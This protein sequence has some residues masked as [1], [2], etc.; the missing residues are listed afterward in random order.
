M[1]GTSKNGSAKFMPITPAR[2]TAGRNT[3]D[4][5][6]RIHDLFASCA[7]RPMWMSNVPS[8]GRAGSDRVEG[9]LQ[10]IGQAG[11]RLAEL[12]VQGHLRPARAAKAT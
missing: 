3:A 7:A 9:A 4:R 1:I 6:V 10:A 5:R 12:V 8:R 11:P 2:T